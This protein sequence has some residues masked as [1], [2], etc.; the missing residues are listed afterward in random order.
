MGNKAGKYLSKLDAA[1]GTPAV[2][3]SEALL[4][5]ETLLAKLFPEAL[6][7]A[8]RIRWYVPH[9]QRLPDIATSISEW[10]G[11]GFLSSIATAD[12]IWPDWQ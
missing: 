6:S 5:S 1:N 3:I 10:L 4:T 2:L 12:M 9:L 8:R 7:I 11:S